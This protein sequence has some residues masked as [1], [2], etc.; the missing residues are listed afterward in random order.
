MRI[1][2][3]SPIS[4]NELR[5]LFG[6]C[7]EKKDFSITYVCTDTR[8]LCEGDLFIGVSGKNFD[9]A[10]FTDTAN[11]MGA[12]TLS[13]SES[14][15]VKAATSDDVLS[16][17]I[18][19]FKSK[20]SH[21]IYTVAITGSV[22]K[23]T[24]KELLLSL[25]GKRFKAHANHKNYNN[26]LGLFHTVLT[27]PEDTELLIAELGMNAP[28]EI[29]AMAKLLTPDIAIITNVGS[30]HVG[31]LGSRK[32][33]AN[34]KLEICDGLNDSGIT[35]IPYGDQALKTAKNNFTF[36][37]D[38]N[39]ANAFFIPLKLDSGGTLFD[40]YSRGKVVC[41]C[42]FHIPGEHNFRCLMGAFSAA[43]LLGIPLRELS[44]GL[45]LLTPDILRP[46]ILNLG[47][48]TV[49]NDSYSSSPEALYET[50]R[51]LTL[52]KQP[53]SAVI[54]D[55][56]ELGDKSAYYHRNAGKYAAKFGYRKLYLV[57]KYARH[58]A[59]GAIAF[60]IKKENIHINSDNDDLAITL[61]AI[62]KGYDGEIILVKA[63]HRTGL[64]R[65]IKMMMERWT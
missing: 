25:T 41:G 24:T 28:G 1:R 62:D 48:H 11:D 65:L 23:T 56:L 44:S 61:D 46:T 32:E 39:S 18:K 50:M 10:L 21:L 45:N 60:G 49:Y 29:K 40:F 31:M 51:M 7:K 47:D 12:F 63:S 57:G 38:N 42:R 19:H 36:S 30:A 8:E 64:D 9:G 27:A 26:L 17:L 4:I 33:I 5:S 16:I 14:A 43:M 53:L 34:A 37:A 15:T 59:E 54:G 52:Y 20:L 22:G 3:S 55:M 35:V 6:Y 13:T 2:L 58:I